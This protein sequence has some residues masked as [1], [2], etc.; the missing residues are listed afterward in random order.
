M[1]FRAFAGANVILRA[2]AISIVSPVPGLRHCAA[3][4]A[5]Y[6]EGRRL[7]C[8]AATKNSGGW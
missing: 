8:S 5:A 3:Y 6:A 4:H 7:C 2:A 1:S